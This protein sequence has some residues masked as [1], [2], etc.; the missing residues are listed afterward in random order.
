MLRTA[1]ARSRERQHTEL[2]GVCDLPDAING[3]LSLVM[4]TIAARLNVL[5]STSD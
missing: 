3:R 1:R 2:H 4:R 5:R